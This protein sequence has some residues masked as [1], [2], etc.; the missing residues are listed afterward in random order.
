MSVVA[1]LESEDYPSAV[2]NAISYGSD[3][4][5]IAD[6]A[7]AIAEAYY[8]Q[9]PE[10]LLTHCLPLLHESI[11]DVCVAFN[12]VKKPVLSRENFDKI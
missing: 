8:G 2:Q 5:T 3:S 6:M 9:V 11:L 1:F 4:D 10:E 12:K 7:G